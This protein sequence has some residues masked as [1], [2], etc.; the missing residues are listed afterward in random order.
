M[1]T[2]RQTIYSVVRTKAKINIEEMAYP[3]IVINTP[4]KKKLNTQ[5]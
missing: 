2:K 1:K 5:A 4:G 3:F